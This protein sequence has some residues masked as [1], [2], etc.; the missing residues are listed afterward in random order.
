[1]LDEHRGKSTQSRLDRRDLKQDLIGAA[2][3]VEHVVYRPEMALQPLEAV[4]Q[5]TLRRLVEVAQPGGV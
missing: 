1:M 2:P 4:A 3:L 5:G